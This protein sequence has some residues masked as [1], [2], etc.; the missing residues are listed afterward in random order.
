MKNFNTTAGKKTNSFIEGIVKL[1]FYIIQLIAIFSMIVLCGKGFTYL[2]MSIWNFTDV[3]GF[4][5]D[6]LHALEIL[7]IAPIPVLITFSFQNYIFA[8]F[9]NDENTDESKNL[10]LSKFHSIINPQE[11]KQAFITSLIG[12]TSTYLLGLFIELLTIKVP[13][14]PKIP[15]GSY[16]IE[17]NEKLIVSNDLI[18]ILIFISIFLVIQILLFKLISSKH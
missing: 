4:L 10:N 17:I 12:I 13:M 5:K 8:I 18:L 6:I 1:L 7:F 16:H 9:P 3:Y 2:F 11:S 15:E 14:D